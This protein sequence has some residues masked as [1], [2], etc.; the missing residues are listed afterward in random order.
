VHSAGLPY[1]AR[2]FTGAVNGLMQAVYSYGGAMLFIEF[3]A[4]MKRPRDFWKGMI[5]AQGF[6]YCVYIFYGMF[7]YGY[8]GQ[9]AVNPAYQGI[10]PYAWQTVGNV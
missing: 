6:I 10:A 3:M 5:C 7:I 1:D 8:Q 2:G 9:Y 4:E